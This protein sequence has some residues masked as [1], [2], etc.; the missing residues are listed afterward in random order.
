MTS[1]KIRFTCSWN[2]LEQASCT[3]TCGAAER[4]VVDPVL[5][6]VSSLISK[7]TIFLV[8]SLALLVVAILLFCI[9]SA[10][11][12]FAVDISIIGFHTLRF[13]RSC[14]VGLF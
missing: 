8:Y 10:M 7:D 2:S 13:G 6:P 1:S 5:V 12:D 11:I 9:C 4:L 14:F 3:D